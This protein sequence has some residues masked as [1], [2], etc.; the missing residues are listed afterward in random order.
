MFSCNLYPSTIQLY[1][2]FIVRFK[3][4]PTLD[5]ST[6]D[7]SKYPVISN[8]IDWIHF[9]FLIMFQ[10]KLSIFVSIAH[11]NFCSSTFQDVCM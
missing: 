1:N 5:I 7:N 2:L 8:N 11:S 10:L 9:L 4:Q 6:T 3:I